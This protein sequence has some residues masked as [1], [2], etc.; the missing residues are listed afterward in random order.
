[1]EKDGVGS[2]V[3]EF[4]GSEVLESVVPGFRVLNFGTG[5]VENPGT[6]EL[7]NSGTD[8]CF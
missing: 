1:V 8:R 6:S 7:R 5:A 4:R 2:G 3:P